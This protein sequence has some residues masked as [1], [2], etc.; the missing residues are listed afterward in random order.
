MQKLINS[1]QNYAWGSK[2]ALTELYGIANP[3]QQP[4]AELWMGAH[5]KSSSRITTANGETVSLRD[6]IEKNKTAMLG[7]A[8]A[9]RFGELPFLFK[10]LCAAQPLSIQ[11]HPNKRNSEIGFAKENA[12]GIPMDAAERNYKDPNH[13][14]ELVFA[15]TPFLAMNA[16]REFSDIVSLLQPVAG[17]HSAIA[18]FLQAPNAERLSQLFASL[19]NMQGEEKSRALAVLKAALNSQQGEP[20]QTIRVISEYYPDDSGLFS[21]LL[22]N[23]VKLNPGEAMFLFAETPHAYLQGVALEVMANS[24]NVLRAGLTPKYID[25]PELVANVRFEPSLP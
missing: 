24:D 17:A 12:A 10:V 13:K 11:V 3:Q 5:P 4:M 9:N 7:E 15:L 21:P 16:F 14:P 18:H 25:I 20:W 2:T 1:V 8:V 22:L 19:L 23:V 6:A